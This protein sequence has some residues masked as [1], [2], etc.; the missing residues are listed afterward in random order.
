MHFIVKSL[1]NN[2]KKIQVK[3][4]MID[5][6]F[7]RLIL[8]KTG[9]SYRS[10]NGSSVLWWGILT[11]DSFNGFIMLLL[12]ECSPMLVMVLDCGLSS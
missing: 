6:K 7:K 12:L 8:L 4:Q 5:T 11:L 1:S 9:N 2:H 10:L 3:S